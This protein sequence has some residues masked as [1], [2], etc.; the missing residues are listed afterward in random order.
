MLDDVQIEEN[1]QSNKL[2]LLLQMGQLTKNH[3]TGALWKYKILHSN[4]DLYGQVS[5]FQVE[6]T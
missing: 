6:T 2:S 4:E 5:K 3:Q 1:K